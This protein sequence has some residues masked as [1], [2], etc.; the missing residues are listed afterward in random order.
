[1]S[2]QQSFCKLRVWCCILI[3]CCKLLPPSLSF[4]S[5]SLKL[6]SGVIPL[7]IYWDGE[8][9]SSG[10]FWLVVCFSINLREGCAGLVTLV[11]SSYV[12]H[13]SRGRTCWGRMCNR[14]M[15]CSGGHSTLTPA[16]KTY[17]ELLW[18]AHLKSLFTWWW[19]KYCFVKNLS[20]FII[21]IIIYIFIFYI[22]N[23]CISSDDTTLGPLKRICLGALACT[24]LHVYWWWGNTSVQI[25][26]NELD[27][28]HKS[29]VFLSVQMLSTS[30]PGRGAEWARP[31]WMPQTSGEFSLLEASVSFTSLCEY[32]TRNMP[33]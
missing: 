26:F 30:L 6:L 4:I 33:I 24:G 21:Y 11:C 8:N 15:S 1:M 28:Q 14:E 12:Q 16:P 7:L 20:S 25:Y 29:W 5:S 23:E 2:P 13:C 19:K 9:L 10:F 18:D 32:V 3:E 31:A 17:M 27:I 22:Y